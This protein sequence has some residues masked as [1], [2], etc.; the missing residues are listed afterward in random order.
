MALTPLQARILIRTMKSDKDITENEFNNID[1]MLCSSDKENHVLAFGIIEFKKEQRIKR[2]LNAITGSVDYNIMNV[3]VEY[4][5]EHLDQMI[6]VQAA[7]ITYQYIEHIPLS[8]EEKISL[9]ALLDSPDSDNIFIGTTIVLNKVREL[10][11][12]QLPRDTIHS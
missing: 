9:I 6:V 5:K 12:S 2:Q 8:D 11:N 3:D 7:Q 4:V 1:N 10:Q